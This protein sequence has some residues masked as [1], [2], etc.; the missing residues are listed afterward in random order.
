MGI[1]GEIRSTWEMSFW[2][3]CIPD[4]V[5]LFGDLL[6]DVLLGDVLLGGMSARC[7]FGWGP[8]NDVLLGRI[9]SWVI[10]LGGLPDEI[11]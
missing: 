9:Y 4:W 5:G 2:V 10:P 1:L 7:A 8:V 3:G 6:D 11:G